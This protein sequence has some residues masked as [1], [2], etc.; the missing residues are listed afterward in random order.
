MKAHLL[1]SFSVISSAFAQDP[2]VEKLDPALD[3][4][5]APGTKVEV[6]TE[7]FRWTEG[8]VWNAETSELLFSDIPN[9]VIHAWSDEKGLRVFMKPSGYTGISDYGK[10]AGSNG[11]TFDK[12]GR[13]FLAE[14]GDRR[15]S[16]LMKNGGKMTVADRFE[17]RRLNSPNDL[18]IHSGGSVYFTDPIYGL[19]EG[20]R[21][22]ARE[23]PYCGVFRTTFDGKITLISK[24]LERPNGIALSHDEKTLFVANSHKG[25]FN[26]YSFPLKE[27]GSAGEMT[28]F[29]DA[30]KLEG[31]GSTD[32]LKTDAEGNIWTTGPGGLLIVS[33]EGKLLGRVLTHQPTSNVAFG[34][35]DGKTVFLTANDRIMRFKRK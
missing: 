18:V 22:M 24:D 17:G 13:L 35:K 31:K 5:I 29:F 3:A 4:L 30:N 21:D 28:L 19:P 8:P 27:D 12:Y 7:G 26:V 16:V 23:L 32:G 34:G 10:E 9:N 15:I 6:I 1:L 11:L 33:K 25:K 20:E 14:H 2:S